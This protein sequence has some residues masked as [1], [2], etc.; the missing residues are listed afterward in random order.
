MVQETLELDN[1]ISVVNLWNPRYDLCEWWQRS[2]IMELVSGGLD[3]VHYQLHVR[4]PNVLGYGVGAEAK[5]KE[6]SSC[7]LAPHSVWFYRAVSPGEPEC[8][9]Y[10]KG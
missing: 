7:P 5:G 2:P 10:G 4:R 3:P 8:I 9:R 6:P 1:G